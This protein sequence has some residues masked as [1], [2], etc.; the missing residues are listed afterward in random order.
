MQCIGRVRVALVRAIFVIAFVVV[1]SAT[2]CGDGTADASIDVSAA[3]SL[4]GALVASAPRFRAGEVRLAFGGSDLL[5]AQIRAGARPDVFVAANSELPQ[6]LARDGLVER[7][8]A[9]VRNELVL[10]VARDDDRLNAVT[11][12]ALPGLRIALGA[13][14]VPVGAYADIA[15]SRMDR[16]LRVRVR[17]AIRSREPDTAGVVG[18]LSQGAVD[19]ALIYRTDVAASSGRLRAVTLP[20]RIQPRI[21]YSAAVV[22]GS[23]RRVAARA[24][25]RDLVSGAA[26]AELRRSGFGAAP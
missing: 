22:R 4:K 6:A 24:Y 17:A 3:T 16:R 19:A 2:G 21:V 12:L 10:A 25:V 9:F 8:V 23:D 1:A 26:S 7:P 14:A 5:A 13:S 11:D 15:I 18:K 20:A